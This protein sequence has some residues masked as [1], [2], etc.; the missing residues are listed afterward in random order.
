MV[1]GRTG[2]SKIPTKKKCAL[3]FWALQTLQNTIR[4]RQTA[5]IHR[6]YKCFSVR[7]PLQSHHSDTGPSTFD[8]KVAAKRSNVSRPCSDLLCCILAILTKMMHSYAFHAFVVT[9]Y[10]TTEIFN[11]FTFADHYLTA[12]HWSRVAFRIVFLMEKQQFVKSSDFW[13]SR[14]SFLDSGDN[15]FERP[16]DLFRTCARNP[17]LFLSHKLRMLLWPL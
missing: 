9:S 8:Y 14:G 5:K 12:P 1:P 2:S 6:K 4:E 3:P 15:I 11:M 10:K 16:H 17:T 13:Y 7:S